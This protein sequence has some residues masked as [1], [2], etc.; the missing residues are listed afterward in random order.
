[1]LEE[2]NEIWENVKN[3][4]KKEF[5]IELVHNEK[6]LKAKMKSYNGKQH[7]LHNN[8]TEKE[9]SKFHSLSV[10]LVDSVFKTGKNY[11]PQVFLQKIKYIVKQKKVPKY[12][13]DDI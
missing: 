5:D 2:Y 3:S 11:Y 4:I 9:G 12:I 10:I 7:K 1:M 13:N 8:E 6:Y